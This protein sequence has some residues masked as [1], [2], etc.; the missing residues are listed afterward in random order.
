MKKFIE[1]VRCELVI[2]WDKCYYTTEK[3]S[4]FYPYEDE[5]YTEELLTLHEVELS[6][7]QVGLKMLN[8]RIYRK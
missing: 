8:K 2:L 5:S 3:R 7:M 6:K 4:R 1:K